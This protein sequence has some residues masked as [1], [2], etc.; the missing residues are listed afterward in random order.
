MIESLTPDEDGNVQDPKD[1]PEFIPND[2]QTGHSYDGIAEFDNPMPGWWKNTFWATIWISVLY[3]PIVYS[4]MIDGS[5]HAVYE[6]EKVANMKLQFAEIGEL[7]PTGAAVTRFL[8]KPSWLSVG[9]AIYKANCVSC[10]GPDAY[11]VIGPN[12]ADDSFKHIRA[13]DDVI[14]VIARGRAN[15]SMPAWQNRLSVNEQVMVS[16]YVA[17]LRGTANG[18]G[19]AP[20]GKPIAPWPDPPEPTD[21]DQKD[22]NATETT[23]EQV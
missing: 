14:D 6:R 22:K 18:E 17:S 19:K 7:E 4:P 2:P 5:V 20:E 3:I 21:E 23:P 9:K 8:N 13:I 10:H 16:A 1:A 15:G 11:G 12:L